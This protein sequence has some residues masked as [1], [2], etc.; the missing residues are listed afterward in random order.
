LFQTVGVLNVIL[1][2]ML[3]LHGGSHDSQVVDTIIF[4][5]K[6]AHGTLHFGIEHGS[7]ECFGS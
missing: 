1:L 3:D 6:I 7:I 2:Q 5:A 4:G